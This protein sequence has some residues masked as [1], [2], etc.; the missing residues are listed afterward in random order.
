V[1]HYA[2]IKYHQVYSGIDVLYHGNQSHLEQDFVLAP[3]AD[4]KKIELRLQGAEK[5]ALDS[6]G[7]LVAGTANGDLLLRRPTAY[8]EANGKRTEVAANFL[9]R[10]SGSVGIRVGAYDHQQELIIDPVLDYATLVGEGGP[11]GAASIAVDAA[12]NA[13]ITGSTAATNFPTTGGAYASTFPSGATSTA[14]VTKM[15]PTGTALVFSTFLGGNGGAGESELAVD[16]NGNVF[17]S[18]STSASNFPVTSGAYQS[19]ASKGGVFVTELQPTPARHIFRLIAGT[20]LSASDVVVDLG[21]GLGH[22][23]LLVS[24]CSRACSMGIEREASYV[25][26]A[27]QCAE[28]LNLKT[29]SFMQQD[30]RAA[31]LSNGT[32]FYLYTPFTGSI[33]SHMLDRLRREAA[34]RRI[35]ICSYGPCT[36]VIAEEPWLEATAAP[37][38]N[39]IA[40]FRSRD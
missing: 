28:K 35:R 11:I 8:Q 5:L 2:G 29:V 34:T 16:G 20:A 26:R 3:G 27:Q 21:S 7:N 4:P 14:F 1:R 25:E 12:G 36:S 31:D 32:V 13:Y 40:I 33:L 19:T 30:A 10:G 15:N 24:I 6:R 9:L 18:G 17:V 22:V 23:P 38:T 39:R 37:E